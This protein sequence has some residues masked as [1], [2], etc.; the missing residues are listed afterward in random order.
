MIAAIIPQ[1]SATLKIAPSGTLEYTA[2]AEGPMIYD[3]SSREALSTAVG[4]IFSY[5]RRIIG[6][7]DTTT[8]A[9]QIS[10]D[11]VNLYNNTEEVTINID[12]YINSI[13]VMAWDSGHA[14]TIT[15]KN[16]RLV[17]YRQQVCNLRTEK[18]NLAVGNMLQAV[19][20]LYE[21]LPEGTKATVSDLF[22]AYT[23]ENTLSWCAR[24]DG[25]DK[26]IVIDREGT[27]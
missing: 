1:I 7:F 19:D 14:I 13:P 10:S 6:C 22:V 16:G 24:L 8:P 20:G 18:E 23:K 26:L 9:L 27:Q 15:L 25:D 3:P 12:Y 4:N 21:T 11:L 17:S 5:V 2:T